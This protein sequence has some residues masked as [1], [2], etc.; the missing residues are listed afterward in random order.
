MLIR[1][2]VLTTCEPARACV[3]ICVDMRAC[4]H[5]RPKRCARMLTGSTCGATGTAR[6]CSTD[7]S[8][9]TAVVIWVM[10]GKFDLGLCFG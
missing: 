2:R 3:W 7:P 6:P 9:R 8:M 4:R 10:V 1:A 5:M